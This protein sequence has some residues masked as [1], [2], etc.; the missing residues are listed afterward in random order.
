MGRPLWGETSLFG[1]LVCACTIPSLAG[2]PFVFPACFFW[3]ERGRS[4][5]LLLFPLVQRRAELTAQLKQAQAAQD[6]LR[7][8]MQLEMASVKQENQAK[9][10]SCSCCFHQKLHVHT[11]AQKH[12][13][14]HTHARTHMKARANAHEFLPRCIF[15]ICSFVPVAVPDGVVRA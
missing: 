5:F 7:Q 8:S 6:A 1:P 13:C 14:E 3:L 10:V 11:G 4:A 12:T 2:S 9:V 15:L